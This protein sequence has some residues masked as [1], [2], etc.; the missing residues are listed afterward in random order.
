[1]RLYRLAAAHGLA[2]AQYNVGVLISKGRGAVQDDAEAV[3]FYYLAAAQ[4]FVHAQTSLGCMF[5]TGRGVVKDV[6]EA[7]RHYHLAAA[8]GGT[9]AIAALKR[10]GA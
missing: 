5:E 9:D 6:A 8:Q 4:C 2:N 7:S 1:M 10:L 3:R